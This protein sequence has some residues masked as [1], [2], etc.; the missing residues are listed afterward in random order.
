MIDPKELT[1]GR[2]LWLP[3]VDA[4]ID[5][6]EAASL[7]GFSRIIEQLVG[8]IAAQSRTPAYYL[9]SQAGMSNVS[10]EGVETGEAGLVMKV[11]ASQEQ[12]NGGLR[13]IAVLVAR[14]LGEDALAKQC[15]RAQIVWKNPR[16]PSQAQAADSFQKML[17]AGLPLEWLLAK[18]LQYSPDEIAAV[19][20]MKAAQDKKDKADAAKAAEALKPVVTQTDLQ[21]QVTPLAGSEAVQP[22]SKVGVQ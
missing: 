1:A 16:N 18:E 17:A 21:A 9:M 19:M 22:N 6:W 2:L 12:Y 4:K 13:D 10:P 8:H 20:D 11:H 15:R 14:Q 3:S 5:S 7:D